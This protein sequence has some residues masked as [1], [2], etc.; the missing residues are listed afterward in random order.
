MIR[1]WSTEYDMNMNTI[2]HLAYRIHI[3]PALHWESGTTFRWYRESTPAQA[4]P[5]LRLLPDIIERSNL[6]IPY[7]LTCGA[8]VFPA[9]DCSCRWNDVLF[10][11]L[12]SAAVLRNTLAC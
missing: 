10:L 2:H 8:R 12:P 4:T 7:A 5:R 3:W 1:A 11:G 6:A 9:Q